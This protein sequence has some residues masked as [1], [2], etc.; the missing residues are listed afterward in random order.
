MWTMTLYRYPQQQTLLFDPS[1]KIP[2]ES[3]SSSKSSTIGLKPLISSFTS[4]LTAYTMLLY[5][6]AYIC[7]VHGLP[8][9]LASAPNVVDALLS[10]R[11]QLVAVRCVGLAV[12]CL[13]LT[14]R[15]PSD[16]LAFKLVPTDVAAFTAIDFGLL[17]EATISAASASRKEA[18]V[19]VGTEDEEGWSALRVEQREPD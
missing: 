14:V 17:L 15:R 13:R 19:E 6:L 3:S 7:H 1:A 9:D 10:L 11:H 2:S 12:L 5:D 8:V 4:F 16:S 18:D